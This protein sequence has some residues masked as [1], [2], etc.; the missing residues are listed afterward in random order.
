M[1]VDEEKHGTVAL[2]A[3]GAHFP[4]GLKRAMTNVSRV[5]TK[6]TYYI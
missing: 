3:G 6:S 2:E 4:Q 1:L 5:M